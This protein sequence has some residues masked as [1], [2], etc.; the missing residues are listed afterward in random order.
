MTF[1]VEKM[2]GM[3]WIRRKRNVQCPIVGMARRITL[4]FKSEGDR[5]TFYL[6]S[7][8]FDFIVVRMN[9]VLFFINVQSVVIDGVR[10]KKELTYISIK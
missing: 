6:F 2:P 4:S 9:Q 3:V 5:L 7:F 1:L 10:I 8:P